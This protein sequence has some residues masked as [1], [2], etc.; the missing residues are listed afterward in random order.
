[1]VTRENCRVSLSVSE[2]ICTVLALWTAGMS[3][4]DPQ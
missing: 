3:R 1:M 2:I 4:D